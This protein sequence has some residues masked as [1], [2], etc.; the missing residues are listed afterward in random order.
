MQDYLIL[1]SIL[2]QKGKHHVF[3]CAPSSKYHLSNPIS[4][5]LTYD[6]YKAEGKRIL[7]PRVITE[8][9]HVNPTS[10]RK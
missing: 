5:L 8:I 4:H 2:S 3:I 7:S 1:D 10:F 9:T 6:S